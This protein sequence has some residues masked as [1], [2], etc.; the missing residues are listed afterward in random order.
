MVVYHAQGVVEF[1][2]FRPKARQ[3]YLVGQFNAWH[4]S[5]M[6]MERHSNGEWERILQLAPG[7]YSFK[8]RADE[9]WFPD[10]AAFGI[11]HGPF[12]LNS[13]LLVDEKRPSDA[14]RGWEDVLRLAPDEYEILHDH[15]ALRSGGMTGAESQFDTEEL[16]HQPEFAGHGGTR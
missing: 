2:F 11:E 12:G 8:Y 4:H 13:V 6:P 3:V 7:V 14:S 10:Y 9:E 1:R 15:P 16:L 5:N